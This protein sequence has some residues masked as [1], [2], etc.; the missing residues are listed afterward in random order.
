[1]A[2]PVGAPGTVACR[3]CGEQIM[4]GSR[5]C[6][7]CGEYQSEADRILMQRKTQATA[8]DSTL[9]GWEIA[10]ALIPCVTNVAC[11]L[12]IVYLV[13]G[14]PKGWKLLGITLIGQIFW[15]VV[16]TALQHAGR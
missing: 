12:S 15:G 4:A 9:A 5:K 3:F 14:K 16:I 1:M 10:I 13:Q 2:P 8:G 7:Y 6:R 11:I